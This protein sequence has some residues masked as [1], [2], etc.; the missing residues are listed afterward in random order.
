MVPASSFDIPMSPKHHKCQLNSSRKNPPAPWPTSQGGTDAPHGRRVTCNQSPCTPTGLYGAGTTK[1]ISLAR[2]LI[3]LIRPIKRL[4]CRLCTSTLSNKRPW[5]KSSHLLSL[6][7]CKHKTSWI[8]NPYAKCLSPWWSCF[9]RMIT[10]VQLL[11]RL[12]RQLVSSPAWVILEIIP[13]F[14]SCSK[15]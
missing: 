13:V 2:L 12:N 15:R 6:L 4:T 1:S 9:I 7:I 11:A 14:V 10:Y 3:K 8:S 5:S